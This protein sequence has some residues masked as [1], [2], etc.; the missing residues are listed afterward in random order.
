MSALITKIT[1]DAERPPA[2][3]STGGLVLLTR[4]AWVPEHLRDQ[5]HQWTPRSAPGLAIVRLL[6]GLEQQGI[7]PDP[8]AV[9]EVLESIWRSVIMESELVVRVFRHP[10][11]PL[12]R[13]R[14]LVED[15]G[16]VSRRVI[17]NNGVGHIVDAYRNL[18][19][20]EVMN[21]HAVGTGT[22]AEAAADAALV[23]ELTTQYNPDSTRATGTQSAPA[24][25][26]YRS[27]GTNTV[28]ATVTVQEHMLTSQAATG[29]G[30]CFDRSLTG[31]QALSAN[32]SIQTE[33]TATLTAGG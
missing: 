26:Q 12:L 20:L 25:N 24:S 23:T 18:V 6:R 21:Y 5:Y 16:V 4:D 7:L 2:R 32:D 28:D 27:T 8:D 1:V 30:V 15:Y 17:T 31:G 9:K 3:R 14:D 29:G 10:H 11:S 22:T 19:E 33:Y 13:G